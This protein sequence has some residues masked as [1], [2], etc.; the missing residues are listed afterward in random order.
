MNK[1]RFYELYL[2]ERGRYGNYDVKKLCN[3]IE[4]RE[5]IVV[6]VDSLVKNIIASLNRIHIDSDVK[7]IL[8]AYIDGISIPNDPA[9]SVW[10]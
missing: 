10:Q 9:D 8:N 6:T 1:D 3:T 5:T 7:E 4:T 2:V